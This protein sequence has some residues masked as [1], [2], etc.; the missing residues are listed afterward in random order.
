MSLYNV[1]YIFDFYKIISDNYV[2]IKD[3]NILNI[4]KN[5]EY[6]FKHLYKILNT[7]SYLDFSYVTEYLMKC[8]NIYYLKYDKIIFYI[9]SK[10]TI[11][12]SDINYIKNMFNRVHITMKLYQMDKSL[13]FFIIFNPSKRYI[14]KKEIIKPKHING[15]FTY[16]NGNYI[17][18]VRKKDSEKVI[19]H[20]LL[21]HNKLIQNDDWDQTNIDIIKNKMNIRKDCILYPNE[22]VIETLACILH[23]SFKAIEQGKDFKML[24]KKELNHSMILYK[25]IKD[26]Q[27]NKLWY[28]KTNAYS[29][30]IL[31]TILFYY[32]DIFLSSFKKGIYDQDIIT[33][34]LINKKKYIDEKVISKKYNNNSLNLIL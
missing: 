28:E 22:A 7:G 5:G 11:N 9:F 24:F 34:I 20:E 2:H 23:V 3:L 33:N 18:I 26:H 17:Y 32:N 10:N 29:Y 6:V 1:K 8:N 15:G 25:K 16:I 12:Y 19:L 21:H 31:R 27:G 30:I 13:T 14:S 4:S